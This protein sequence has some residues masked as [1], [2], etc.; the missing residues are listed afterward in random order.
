MMYVQIRVFDHDV[1]MHS[2]RAWAHGMIEDWNRENLFVGW[3]G[4]LKKWKVI[5]IYVLNGWL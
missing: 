2:L 5:A 1:L 3:D 4:S